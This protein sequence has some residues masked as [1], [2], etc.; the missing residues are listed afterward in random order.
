MFEPNIQNKSTCRCWGVPHICIHVHVC[1]IFVNRAS[2]TFVVH[3]KPCLKKPGGAPCAEGAEKDESAQHEAP[4][5]APTWWISKCRAMHNMD[6]HGAL[7]TWLV[8]D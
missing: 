5:P 7:N 6:F 8:L 4:A 2:H 1:M 3:P